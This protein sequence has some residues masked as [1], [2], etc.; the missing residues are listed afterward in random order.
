MYISMFNKIIELERIA[1]ENLHEGPDRT[2][3]LIC[4]NR[5][6]EKKKQNGW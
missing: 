3:N 2:Q 4:P 6:F 5:N 1:A